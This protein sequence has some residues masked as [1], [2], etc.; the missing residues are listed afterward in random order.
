MFRRRSAD[1]AVADAPAETA[2]SSRPTADRTPDRSKAGAT[3]SRREAEAARK[4]RLGA[5]PSDPKERRRAER[6]VRNE[7]YQRQ[8]DAIKSG[9]ARNYPARDFGPARAFVRDYVDGRLRL[10]E[11]LMPIVVMAWATLVLRSAVIY[12]Y[13]SFVMEFVVL[14]GIV[15]GVL[16][17]VRVKRAVR[18]RFGE[19]EARGTGFYAFSRAAMPRFLRQPRPTVDFRGNPK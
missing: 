15:L 1:Q 19:A 9:D 6:T 4:V 16:L 3:P 8:R 7:S 11:F 17:N 2:T 14:V 10:I 13:A 18:E 12:A 5:M